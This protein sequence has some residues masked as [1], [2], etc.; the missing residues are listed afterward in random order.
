MGSDLSRDVAHS[1]RILLRLGH[2]RGELAGHL[3]EVQPAAAVRGTPCGL[4]LLDRH[5]GRRADRR[6]LVPDWNWRPGRA[7]AGVRRTAWCRLLG[8]TGALPHPTDLLGGKLE[9]GSSSAAE[10][11]R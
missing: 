1:A 9:P 3:C 5:S 6:T 4:G 11:P 2:A 10:R 7:G 8:R